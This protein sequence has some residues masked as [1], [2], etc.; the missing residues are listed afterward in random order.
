MAVL[1][2]CINVRRVLF[3]GCMKGPVWLE[4]L[5]KQHPNPGTSALGDLGQ[6]KA[7]SPAWI[8]STNRDGMSNTLPGVSVSG[9]Y[10]C[11]TRLSPFCRN[12]SWYAFHCSGCLLIIWIRLAGS[13]LKLVGQWGQ[14]RNL[15]AKFGPCFVPVR[16]PTGYVSLRGNRNRTHLVEE[17]GLTG[18]ARRD[19][20]WASCIA[21]SCVMLSITSSQNGRVYQPANVL[22]LMVLQRPVWSW[23]LVIPSMV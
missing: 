23:N 5:P 20:L 8:L 7:V 18:N 4:E 6:S 19:T 14:V 12:C 17:V 2:S 1:M 22:R 13:E 9:L 10:C 21:N 11:F 3:K 15:V 16:I